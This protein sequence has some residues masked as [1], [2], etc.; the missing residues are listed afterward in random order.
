VVSALRVDTHPEA[1]A[2]AT[3]TSQDLPDLRQTFFARPAKV[4]ATD[5][6]GCLLVKRQPNGELLERVIVETEA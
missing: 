6:F 5:L 1:T 3:T 2:V 4:V